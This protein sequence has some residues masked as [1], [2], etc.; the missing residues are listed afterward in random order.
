VRWREKIDETECDIYLPEYKVGLE[1][2][3]YPWHNRHEERD[4]QKGDLLSEKGIS[5]FRLRDI[6]LKP[7][8]PTDTFYSSYETH[9]SILG[10]LLR[11]LT[12]CIY[13]SEDD[14]AKISDYL[15]SNQLLNVQEYRKMISLL[16][17]PIPEKSLAHLFPKLAEEWNFERNKP[18]QP[19][20]FTPKSH[21]KVWWKCI[22]GHDWNA[23]VDHRTGGRGCPKCHHEKLGNINRMMATKNGKTLADKNPSLAGE[24]HP[25]KNVVLSPFDVS[26]MSGKKVWWICNKGHEWEATVSNRTYNRR[27]CPYCA[28]Q[29]VAR[30]NNLAVRY[31]EIA[32]L[33]H[34]TRNGKLTPYEVM[35]GSRRK[36]WW[37][38]N[39]GCMNGKH[40]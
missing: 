24:W 8:A 25:T 37:I 30:D 3:G 9:I 15:Q 40:H 19:S 36:V 7:T 17:G 18:L 4:K 20:M 33:W 31:P 29:R 14:K 34:P 1:I 32:K 38:C 21:V 23:T 35:P 39:Y 11:S 2:D 12:M 13:F 26:P 27:G 5:L 22:K 10:R 6:R 28:G 16:P